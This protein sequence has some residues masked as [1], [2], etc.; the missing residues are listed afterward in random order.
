M[1]ATDDSRRRRHERVVSITDDDLPDAVYI[2]GD[3]DARSSAGRRV[4]IDDDDANVVSASGRDLRHQMENRV[5]DR[6][7]EIRRRIV[8][9]RTARF[10]V[11]VVVALI[12]VGVLTLLGSS[13]FGIRRESVQV[14]GAVYTDPVALEAVID[15][16]VGTPVLLFDTDAARDQLEAI[17]W[18][19]TA[20]VRT[21]FPFGLRIDLRER[22]P[23]LSY[24]APDGLFRVLD[25]EGRVLDVIDGWPFEY[26]LLISGDSPN[27]PAGA[28]APVG[29]VGAARLVEKTEHTAA[30]D[31]LHCGLLVHAA[32]E[33]DAD[34]V[35]SG[36]D[37]LGGVNVGT[38]TPLGERVVVIGGGN[39]AVD[40][41]R[42]ARRSGAHV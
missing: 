32:G 29:H 4:I 39:T 21:D 12:V 26:L 9:R 7:A 22:E 41:A 36:V 10:G 33:H 24:P 11:I 15:Q 18:V 34:G 20:L 37:Y 42:S 8:N 35:G 38:P 31:R 40:A 5:R 2:E 27:L 30:V 28:Y 17:P 3:L 1:D 16:A 23:V 6:R 13:L 19:D 14:T 25:A